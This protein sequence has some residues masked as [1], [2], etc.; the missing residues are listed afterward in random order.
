MK[1]QIAIKSLAKK[2]LKKQTINLP[3]LTSPCR[4]QDL[5]TQMVEQQVASYNE[6]LL[7]SEKEREIPL[8]ENYLDILTNTGKV[9]FGELYNNK[10]ADVDSAISNAL[11]CF[12]DGLFAV[13]VDDVQYEQLT[14][15]IDLTE[16]SVVSF[17]RL[18]FLA[19]SFW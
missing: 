17:V 8:D 16:D 18:T 2:R 13:F 4:L 14:D 1:I 9:S 6:R 11:E 12:T 15:S 3:N 19:G 10:P 7:K 5:L